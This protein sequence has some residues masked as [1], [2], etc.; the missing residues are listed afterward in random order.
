MNKYLYY[1][2]RIYNKIELLSKKY[3]CSIQFVNNIPANACIINFENRYLIFASNKLDK[4]LLP[5]T[6]LHEFG[7]IRFKTIRNNPKKYNYFIELLSNLYAINKLI[8]MFPLSKKI[9]LIL[10]TFFREKSLYNYF[11]N[12]TKVGGCDIYEKL[13]KNQ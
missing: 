8:F 12:N 6:I 7:H 2:N 9:I 3:K 1:E 5:L 11:I 10:L 4:R 13:S